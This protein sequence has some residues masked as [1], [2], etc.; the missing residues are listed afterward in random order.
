MHTHVIYFPPVCVSH[1]NRQKLMKCKKCS[2]EMITIFDHFIN[3]THSSNANKIENI[4]GDTFFER[5]RKAFIIFGERWSVEMKHNM[6]ASL[7]QWKR[8]DC[9]FS[10]RYKM[11]KVEST[12]IRFCCV[13]RIEWNM[14]YMYRCKLCQ[15]KKFEKTKKKISKR[16]LT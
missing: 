11:L 1:N 13:M 5:T 4:L 6:K 3:S 15:W 10:L 9:T 16:I 12:Q 8:T 2:R 14:I 7:R